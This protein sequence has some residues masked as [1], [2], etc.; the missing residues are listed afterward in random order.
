MKI[1]ATL[2]LATV[3]SSAFG[4]KLVMSSS[5]T[6]VTPS[7]GGSNTGSGSASGGIVWNSDWKP[8][9]FSFGA[10]GSARAE[11]SPLWGGSWDA[12]ADGNMVVKVQLIWKETTVG[13]GLPASVTMLTSKS[14]QLS[15]NIGFSGSGSASG[16]GTIAANVNYGLMY[17]QNLQKSLYGGGSWDGKMNAREPR[18]S[19]SLSMSDFHLVT[20]AGSLRKWVMDI[21]LTM[22]SYKARATASMSGIPPIP[23]AGPRT[24]NAKATTIGSVGFTFKVV[25]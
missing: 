21:Q 18:I 22:P 10:I 16:V 8:T 17:N 9:K 7:I 25:P 12:N 4:G 19:T 5:W 13:E 3:V 6:V 23:T 2:A 1:F 20:P 11:Y 24:V 15:G 14:A